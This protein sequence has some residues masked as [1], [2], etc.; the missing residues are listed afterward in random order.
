MI[1]NAALRR[2]Q[3]ADIRRRRGT[4]RETPEDAGIEADALADLEA[5]DAMAPSHALTRRLSDVRREELR[6]LW[7]GRIPAGKVSMLVGDPGLGKSMVT[8]GI[9]ATVSRGGRWPIHG[10]GRAPAGDV[11][12][13]SA[14]DDP[15]D[16]IRP[17]L[18][19][20]GA[21]LERVH[22]LD[23]IQEVNEDGER[24][25]RPWTLSD[26]SELERLIERL[27][28]CR[29]L[30]IDPVS[31]YLAA[32]DSHKNSDVRALLAPLADLAARHR[33]AVLAVSHLNKS[34]GPAIYRTTGS[35][36]FTAAARSVYCVTKDTNDPARRL[37]VP[38]KAN[39]APDATAVAYRIGTD[40]TGTP[41][42]EWEPDPFEI[43]ANEALASVSGDP[44]ER[45]ERQEAAEWLRDVLAD[46]PKQAS[47]I[48]KEARGSF[49]ERT[50][51]RARAE[52]GARIRREGFGGGSKWF[53][54]A[55]PTP[56]QRAGRNGEAGRNGSASGF[57]GDG[58]DL[59]G[60]SGQTYVTCRDGAGMEGEL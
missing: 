49:S 55:V 15:G 3:L 34:Q 30:V 23:G 45:T 33:L 41:R 31:A 58:H 28:D 43:D 57:Q 53:I 27:P 18:E 25:R 12:L 51:R 2:A 24:V 5:A 37:V 47:E 44:D 38:I 52:I 26:L 17:R 22:A 7:P 60:H 54:P 48:F 1:A 50:L 32:V 4:N 9:A 16:T 8:L 36:A 35:L 6:W 56:S 14:E 11:V 46:G 10:E 20:A 19:A 40:E 13:V 39:L 21:D 29:L 42:L 59:S